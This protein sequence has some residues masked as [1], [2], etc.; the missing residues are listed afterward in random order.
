MWRAASRPGPVSR[1]A[2][3]IPATRT[4]A[5]G[6][7]AALLGAIAVLAM[8]PIASISAAGAR[9]VRTAAAGPGDALSGLSG[10]SAPA[11]EPA[12]ASSE[13]CGRTVALVAGHAI[14][15][16][17]VRACVETGAAGRSARAYYRNDTGRPVDVKLS[18]IRSNGTALRLACRGLAIE[19]S[20]SCETLPQLNAGGGCEAIAVASV[21]ATPAVRAESGQADG[22]PL[23]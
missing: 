10:V 20:G 4:P 22:L 3:V 6:A 14:G 23:H 17:Q 16:A 9:P 1:G 19:R 21:G 2:A 13:L 11:A 15:D 5:G 7:G 12:N 8:I 18:L